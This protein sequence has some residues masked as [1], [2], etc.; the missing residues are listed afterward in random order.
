MNQ[1]LINQREMCPFWIG[2]VDFFV[3]CG[4]RRLFNQ[5]RHSM[6][7]R[8]VGLQRS[9]QC[10]FNAL[11]HFLEN[12]RIIQQFAISQSLILNHTEANP[13]HREA[14]EASFASH[15]DMAI[16]IPLRSQSEDLSSGFCSRSTL[17]DREQAYL[18]IKHEC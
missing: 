11:N 14:P 3:F 12:T 6:E 8:N 2:I 7:Y 13:Q 15:R 1:N 18:R 5:Q 17:G 16:P 9:N 4:K 10:Q